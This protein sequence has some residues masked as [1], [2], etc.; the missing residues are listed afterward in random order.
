MPKL[1]AEFTIRGYKL[2]LFIQNLQSAI[3]TRIINQANYGK[4]A[5][6]IAYIVHSHM[7]VVSQYLYYVK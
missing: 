4:N 7:I 5:E 3:I 6:K 1:H 2:Q